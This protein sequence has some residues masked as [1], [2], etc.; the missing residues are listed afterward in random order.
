MSTF[1]SA[2]IC[3]L[4]LWPHQL[5]CFDVYW[6]QTDKQAKIKFI[7]K[8]LGSSLSVLVGNPRFKP[9]ELPYFLYVSIFNIKCF[10]FNLFLVVF[11]PYL[12]RIPV[13]EESGFIIPIQ[14]LIKGRDQESGFIIPIQGLIKGRD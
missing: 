14:G 6:T 13:L 4:H 5:S 3:F 1:F 7:K 11:L 8:D 10:I 9:Y 2:K 12:R